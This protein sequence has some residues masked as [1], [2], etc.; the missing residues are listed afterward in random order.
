MTSVSVIIHNVRSA[1]NVGAIFRT[2]DG[3]GV[4]HLYLSGYTP[5]PIDRFGRKRS[6]IEKTALGA[7]QT[8]PWSTHRNLGSLIKKLKQD[9]VYVVALEQAPGAT[10]Y[11]SIKIPTP[12]AVVVGNEVRGLSKPTLAACD[13]TAYIP[14][15]GR[16]ESLNVGIALAVFLFSLRDR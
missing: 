14:M 1:H 12:I 15:S 13:A 7:E 9:G 11:A 6:D 4:A 10:V 5:S 2:A 8:V 16:K 3:A